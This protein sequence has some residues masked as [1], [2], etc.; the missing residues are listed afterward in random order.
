MGKCTDIGLRR[1][2]KGHWRSV[3]MPDA[4]P[5]GKKRGR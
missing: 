1:Y 2:K 4:A 3:L 5:M